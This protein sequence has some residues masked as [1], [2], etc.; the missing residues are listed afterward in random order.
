M[1]SVRRQGSRQATATRLGV[2][3]AALVLVA[4]ACSS[5]R[6]S[7][8]PD[9]GE[10]DT[11]SAGLPSDTF[12]DLAVPCGEGDASGATDQGVTDDSITIG[13]GDDSGYSAAPGLN[14]EMGDSIEA[15]IE[16]CNSLG[17]INGRELVGNRYDAA[18]N[19]AGQVIVEAC[20]QDFA[21]VGQGIAFDQNMEADRIACQLVSVP[22]FVVSPDAAH[23]PMTYQPVPNPVDSYGPAKEQIVI[24]NVEGSDKIGVVGRD[25]NAAAV[26]AQK[27]YAAYEAAGAE[28]L[29]CGVEVKS[30]GGDNYPALVQRL[31][32][33]GATMLIDTATA[34]PPMYAFMD[35]KKTAGYDATMAFG[36]PWYVDQV[37]QAN[38]TGITE[39]LNVGMAF[40]PFEN[41]DSNKAV[42]DYLAVMAQNEDYK[43]GQLGMQS[44]SAFLLWAT[45]ADACESD[46]TRQC[47]VDQ[48]SAVSEWTGGG[49]HATTDPGGN[50]P[51]KCAVLVQVKGGAFEQVAPAE[52]GEFECYE[53][54]LELPESSW[55]VELNEDR[56]S[57]T[58]LTDDIITPSS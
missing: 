29:D 57:T 42:A 41:A 47:L 28:L 23:G 2:L 7:E 53:D 14:E 37:L 30:A 31:E 24:D 3:A 39:G 48:L 34:S 27:V 10:G 16:W 22:G 58:Y 55:G 46:L 32:D 40:Q 52:T 25:N 44:M 26:A 15:A 11:S 56:I 35:A 6:N 49:M 9:E 50:L 4:G 20:A 43:S 38:I 45:A 36:T 21:L 12:G 51:P 33:C 17:G 54:Y 1:R 8:D 13:F 18:L 5:D 19:N